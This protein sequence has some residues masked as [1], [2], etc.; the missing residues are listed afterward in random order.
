MDSGH[1][2]GTYER[3]SYDL[4]PCVLGG[5]V[6]TAHDPEGYSIPGQR[7]ACQHYAE[8]LDARVVCEYVEP[9][10]SGTNLSRPA[11]QRM[12]SEL[13]DLTDYVIFYDLSRVARDDFDALWLLRE[14]EGRGCKLESTLERVDDTPAGKL[15]Y[16]VMAGV[17]AF[18]SRG[19]AEKVKLGLK[20][21]FLDGGSS[22][23]ARL[24]YL[25]V[26]EKVGE[27]DVAA[28]AVDPE[29][30]PLIRELFDLAATGEH[31]ITSLDD[32][33]YEAGLRTRSTPARPSR[34]VART[35]STASCATTTTPA[36]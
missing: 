36:W 15:L 1:V 4:P 21:K 10:K 6:N 34:R 31:T 12:L 18:R 9:G 28:I 14:I 24:G 3:H 5:E 33:I 8:G 29:R 19:D 27:R 32:L 11:L 2:G 22:G 16:T 13:D 20:R 35:R 7:D 23:P 30:A 26:R 25:N 17:N